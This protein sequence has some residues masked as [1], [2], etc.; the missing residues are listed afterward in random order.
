MKVW[1]AIGGWSY[2]GYDEPIGIT[3]VTNNKA[4]TIIY[5]PTEGNIPILEAGRRPQR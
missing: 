1:V 2:E 4:P 5:V 3:D